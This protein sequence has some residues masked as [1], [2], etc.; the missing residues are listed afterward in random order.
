VVTSKSGIRVTSHQRA[1][2]HTGGNE[3]A[4]AVAVEEGKIL[5]SVSGSIKT[6]FEKLVQIWD[7][8]NVPVQHR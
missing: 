2:I 7:K 4:P 8:N 3:L 1:R 6:L 5:L